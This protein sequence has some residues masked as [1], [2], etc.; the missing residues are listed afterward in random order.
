MYYMN[1]SIPYDYLLILIKQK[2]LII[3]K[4]YFIYLKLPIDRLKNNFFL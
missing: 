4:K 2:M 1:F 3:C